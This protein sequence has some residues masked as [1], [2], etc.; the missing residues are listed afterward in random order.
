MIIKKLTIASIFLLLFSQNTF[1]K[2]NTR[3]EGHY[4]NFKII[5]TTLKSDTKYGSKSEKDINFSIG[6]DRIW[7]HDHILLMAGAHYTHF[8]NSVAGEGSYSGTQFTL[9]DRYSIRTG[10][11]YEFTKLYVYTNLEFGAMHYYKHN[12]TNDNS[13][14]SDWNGGLGLSLG[15]GIHITQ[16]AD[17]ILE[18]EM[19]ENTVRGVNN[20][21][22]G[23]GTMTFPY[24]M[25][26]VGVAYR[27]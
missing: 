2:E 6:Y 16:N 11:G 8:D 15:T 12:A 24:E 19:N 20:N 1:A 21:S 26:K 14:K 9:G 10:I 7:N 5:E 17:L 13:V 23:G 4:V 27:F 22:T 3:T 25:L 18:Y